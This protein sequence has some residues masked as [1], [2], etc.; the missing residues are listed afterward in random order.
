MCTLSCPAAA[1][2]PGHVRMNS[3]EQRKLLKEFFNA[4]PLQ[5]PHAS[6]VDP[7]HAPYVE[8]IHAS[9][10]RDPVGE[11]R[12][13]LDFQDAAA[14]Y[15]FSGQRGSGKTT[16]LLRL[17]RSLREAGHAAFYVDAL[18]Y[19]RETAPLGITDL[20]VAVLGAFSEAYLAR[21]GA[22][23][24]HSGSWE[25]FRDFLSRTRV[26]ANETSLKLGGFA[27]LQ[28]AL[29]DN[30]T[31]KANLRS[32]S[33]NSLDTFVKAA[34]EFVDRMVADVRAPGLATDAK[35]V[36]V[37]D[38]LEKIRGSGNNA[39]TVFQSLSDVF[40]GNAHNLRFNTLHVVY[41]VP[42]TLPLVAPGIQALYGGVHGLSHIK[43]ETPP[44][45]PTEANPLRQGTR[46]EPGIDL[47]LS[48]LTAHFPRWT[49]VFPEARMRDV[50][51][52][53]GG[54]L[55]IFF[56]IIR[57]ALLKPPGEPLPM[58]DGLV[59]EHAVRDTRAD[60]P[61]STEDREWLLDVAKTKTPA[62][63]RNDGMATLARLFDNHLILDYRNGSAWC[64]VLPLV[65]ESLHPA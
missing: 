35:V 23:P 47:M 41:C 30:P 45:R 56:L 61:L 19:L 12:Q 15:L 28:L 7:A 3:Y 18:D 27:D 37:V 44:A 13:A 64:D 26:V 63:D 17:T 29:K 43:V 42:P 11:L 52:Q 6:G 36:L 53:S 8:G 58:R 33:E 57:R 4:I 54:N 24:R 60:Y 14:S 39:A 49:E 5:V 62:L 38:S 16:E 25:R 48:V 32:S 46:H 2:L 10:G 22:D 31:F 51:H 65:R 34:R 59:L 9:E 21:Q 55:R 1:R 50:A 20:L 40:F